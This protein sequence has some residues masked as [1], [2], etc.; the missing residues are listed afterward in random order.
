MLFRAH[1]KKL[2]NTILR[3]I[4]QREG[5]GYRV[6]ILGREAIATGIECPVL[7]LRIHD[8]CE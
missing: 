8:G 4:H 7:V 5:E 3:Y 6:A 2:A 1:G